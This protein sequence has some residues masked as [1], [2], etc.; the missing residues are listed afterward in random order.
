MDEKIK[1]MEVHNHKGQVMWKRVLL[2]NNTE[3]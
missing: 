2:N 1:K 3:H